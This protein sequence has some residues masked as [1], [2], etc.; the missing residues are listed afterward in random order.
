M[1]GVDRLEA[2]Q[3]ADADRRRARPAST[4]AATYRS[5]WRRLGSPV[6]GSVSAS[7]AYRATVRRRSSWSSRAAMPSTNTSR[8]RS[9]RWAASR[10]AV[11]V[12]LVRRGVVAG[13]RVGQ[14]AQPGRLG[15]AEGLGGDR[16]ASPA[17]SARRSAGRRRSPGRPRRAGAGRGRGRRRRRRPAARPPASAGRRR[18]A[19]RWPARRRGPARSRSRPGRSGAAAPSVPATRI[20]A[21]SA[22]ESRSTRRQPSVSPSWSQGHRVAQPDARR[23]ERLGRRCPAAAAD[24]PGRLDGVQRVAVEAQ[25]GVRHREVVPARSRC[26]SPGPP[27]ARSVPGGLHQV[28]DA[29][30]QGALEL[31]GQRGER[32]QVA[33]AGTARRRRGRRRRPAR[34]R[35]CT[36]RCGPG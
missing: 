1:L 21:S 17:G 9:L 3:V 32:V 19:R 16:H 25:V 26:P 23:G 34:R 2:V 5:R 36:R 14:A 29:P 11:P 35:R 12:G 10:N 7:S 6:S 31:G 18:R 13:A 24:L 30:L 27:T 4:I 28:G 33:V 22:L 15:R 8:S 20:R